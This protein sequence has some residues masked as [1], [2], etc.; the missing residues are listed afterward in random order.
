MKL[1]QNPN[2]RYVVVGYG[3]HIYGYAYS[4]E[5]AKK[6]VWEWRG[7]IHIIDQWK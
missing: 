7:E 3:G 4:L 2:L 5:Y 6:V 1:S